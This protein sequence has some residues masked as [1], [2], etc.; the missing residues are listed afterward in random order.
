M[1]SQQSNKTPVETSVKGGGSFVK[2]G[3]NKASM[4]EVETARNVSDHEQLV[5]PSDERAGPVQIL[6][7]HVPKKYLLRDVGDG[8]HEEIIQYLL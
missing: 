3:D 6:R 7:L 8:I 1:S 5:E 2:P 4:I